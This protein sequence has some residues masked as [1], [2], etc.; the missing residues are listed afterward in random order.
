VH[1][2]GAEHQSDEALFLRLKK[3]SKITKILL[4]CD[5]RKGETLI[6]NIVNEAMHEILESD[7]FDKLLN[8]CTTA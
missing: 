6:E 5:A 2:A 3:R 8:D 7:E 1:T 4:G